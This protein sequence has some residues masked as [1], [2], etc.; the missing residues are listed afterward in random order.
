MTAAGVRASVDAVLERVLMVLMSVMVLNVLW[1]VFTRFVLR[2]PSSHTEELARYLL[3]WLGLLGA[4][5]AVGRNMHLAID[6]LTAKLTGRRKH[7]SDL[8]ITSCVA[9]F[10]L[11]VVVI[12]GTNLV[13][14]TL[15]L[16]QFSAALRVKLGYVYLVVPISGFLMTLY[17]GTYWLES[18]RSLKETA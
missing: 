6:I 14:L 1:Q 8:L 10:S 17:A 3:V 13:W 5:Y 12:G 15:E 11:G 2:D 4:S 16:Q 7:V 9:F 18:L